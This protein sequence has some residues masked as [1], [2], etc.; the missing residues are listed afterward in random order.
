MQRSG[1]MTP[2]RFRT[3]LFSTMECNGWKF[4]WLLLA[5]SM[6]IGL[7]HFRDDVNLGRVGGHFRREKDACESLFRGVDRYRQYKDSSLSLSQ[8]GS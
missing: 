2:N 4:G 5:G 8:N 1:V 6:M 3:L 7:P